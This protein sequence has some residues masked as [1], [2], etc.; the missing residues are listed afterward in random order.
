MV[1]SLTPTAATAMI[2]ARDEVG[3]P[4]DYGI[5]F[6]SRTDGV[7]GITF[8]FVAAPEA[9]DSLGGSSKMR[10]YVEALVHHNLGDAT[11]DYDDADGSAELIIR[12]HNEV[13]AR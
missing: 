6:F 7:A 5:R 4:S 10:T 12:P 8:E 9:D 13:R 11:V 3:A 1:F 2:D